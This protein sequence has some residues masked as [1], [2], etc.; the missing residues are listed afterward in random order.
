MHKRLCAI[1]MSI[2]FVSNLKISSHVW[3]VRHMEIWSMQL[4][5]FSPKMWSW[6]SP[7]TFLSL[8]KRTLSLSTEGCLYSSCISIW[9]AFSVNLPKFKRCL[10]NYAL[11]RCVLKWAIGQICGDNDGLDM[12]DCFMVSALLSG[13]CWLLN[14][15]ITFKWLE[16]VFW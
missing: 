2:I 8:E 3:T 9:T 4:K 16:Q 1:T 6:F 12:M 7:V 15:K 14:K 11:A 5:M 10:L 13:A